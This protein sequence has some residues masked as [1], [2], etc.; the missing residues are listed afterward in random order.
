MSTTTGYGR[1]LLGLM[2]GLLATGPLLANTATLQPAKDNT[3]YEPISQDGFADRSDGAGATMFVGKVKDADADPGPGTRPAVRRGVLAFNIAGNIPAGATINSVQLT[4]Y[5]DKVAVTTA[6]N[7]SLYRLLSDWGEGTSNT[8]SSQQGRGEPPTTGDATWHHTFYPSQFWSLPGGDYTLTASVTRSVGNTGFYTFGSTS[9]MV[10]DVQSWLN[11]PTQNDGWIIIGTESTTQ[12]TKR[13][14]TRENTGLTNGVS[15]RPTLVIDYT[16]LVASGGCCQ[17]ITCSVQT[18]ANCLAAG[19][20]Y[21][22]NGTSCS[23]NPCFV[24][25]GACCAGNGT[26]SEVSQS[27]CTGGGGTYQGDGSTCSAVNCPILL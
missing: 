13:F 23:P 21:Q 3:L 1:I 9:G 15:W 10:A 27:T 16:P 4:M 25:T 11:T 12:T 26:C 7:V 18:S 14:A 2:M 19:G 22:G 6:Y 8:G 5:V 24:A 17:G 20:V